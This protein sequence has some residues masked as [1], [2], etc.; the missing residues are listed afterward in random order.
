MLEF[1]KRYNWELLKKTY[2]AKYVFLSDVYVSK[3]IKISGVL[4]GVCEIDDLDTATTDILNRGIE[5][6]PYLTTEGSGF[7]ILGVT[8]CD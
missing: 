8:V 3:G 5:C 7:F 1:G 4:E 6:L 2:P